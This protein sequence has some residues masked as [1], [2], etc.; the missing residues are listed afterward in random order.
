MA[1]DHNEF[2]EFLQLEGAEP[3]LVTKSE[4]LAHVRGL[5]FPISDRQLTFYV[6]E[7]LMPRSVRVGTRAGAYPCLVVSLLT[8]VL[9]FREMG[10]PIEA[11][12]ELVPVW[13]FLVR[14][15]SQDRLDLA[16]FDYVVRQRLESFEA[17]LAVPELV[18][19]VFVRHV[20]SDCR[21]KLVIVD[22]AGREL[23]VTAPE[24]TIGFAAVRQRPEESG[25]TTPEWW[26]YRR[27]TLAVPP[28]DYETDPMTVI[29]GAG[30]NAPLPSHRRQLGHDDG[31]DGQADESEVTVEGVSGQRVDGESVG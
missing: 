8:W 21:R 31:H 28:D 30:P 2:L 1:L 13:K 23:P 24:A 25:G 11:I 20:C 17:I 14:A 10:V 29:L 16:E 22:K 19:E 26:G 15:R 9:R 18:T 5:G 27:M 4:L 3:R 6:S 7:G 12:K